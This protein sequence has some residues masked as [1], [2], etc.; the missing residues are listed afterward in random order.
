VLPPGHGL[1]LKGPVINDFVELVHHALEWKWMIDTLEAKANSLLNG[2][3]SAAH[4][5]MSGP[6]RRV[7][8]VK[9]ITDGEKSRNVLRAKLW[10]SYNGVYGADE[11]LWALLVARAGTSGLKETVSGL[12]LSMKD[13]SPIVTTIGGDGNAFQRRGYYEEGFWP[14]KKKK[15]H[16]LC[17][18]G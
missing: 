3:V 5:H 6:L 12:E 18:C 9:S 1:L 7:R 2:Q 8:K 11:E 10:I 16:F 14:S 15:A 4:L 17:G 13:V